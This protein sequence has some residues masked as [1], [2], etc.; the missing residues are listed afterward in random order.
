MK[1]NVDVITKAIELTGQ[2]KFQEAEM[3]LESVLAKSPQDVIA[4]YALGTL[5][6]QAKKHG[7]AIQILTSA[8]NMMSDDT[9]ADEKCAT[10]VNLSGVLRAEG[11]S[12]LAMQASEMVLQLQNPDTEQGRINLSAA[13]NNMAAHY[14][15]AGN[16]KRGEE[17]TRKAIEL[18]PSGNP[19]PYANLALLLL[20]QGKW[21]EAWQVYDQRMRLPRIGN[22]HYDA[23]QWDGKKTGTLVLH[24]EQGLGDELLYLT[25]ANEAKQFC[26][27]LV[28]EANPRM[29][30]LLRRSLNCEVYGDDNEVRKYVHKIDAVMPMGS[31]GKYFR[32]TDEDFQNSK[33][34]LQPDPERVAYWRKQ[35]RLITDKPC[36]ALAWHG[37]S[38]FTHEDIRNPKIDYFVDLVQDANVQFVSVQYTKNADFQAALFGIP[39]WQQAIDDID[40][41]AALIAAC[42]CTVSVAQTALHISGAMGKPTI[43]L[44]NNKPA[45]RYGLTGKRMVWYPSATLYRQMPDGDWG[46]TFK[47]V[48]ADLNQLENK[49]AA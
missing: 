7:I 17:L 33:P 1:T 19:E 40:E 32:N 9:M 46:K 31:L 26:D 3:L 49:A 12:K 28:I 16:P 30:S 36:V 38:R 11:H 39:H 21:Q 6:A 14:L 2:H 24:G 22:R 27:R 48:I 13:Y 44:I 47:R 4:L 18:D 29:K 8:V 23:P 45:W 20:E 34:Y 10:L 15:N 5:Y 41:Q 37:G 43:G 35:L 42:D 25:M